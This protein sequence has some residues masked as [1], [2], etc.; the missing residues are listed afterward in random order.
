MKT[1]TTQTIKT[2]SKVILRED[3]LPRHSRSIP[4][5]MGYTREQFAWRRTLGRL[6]G[7][8]KDFKRTGPPMV[9]TV[10][11]LFE[12]GNA[13]VIFGDDTIIGINKTELVLAPR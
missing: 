12:S 9:G 10:S 11:R 4:A 2:G 13:N 8:D 5:H 3:T 6:L 1:T 7:R